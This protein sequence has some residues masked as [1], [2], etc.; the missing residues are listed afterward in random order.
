LLPLVFA[1]KVIKEFNLKTILIPKTGT[2]VPEY[3]RDFYLPDPSINSHVITITDFTRKYLIDNYNIPEDDI[4]LIYQGTDISSFKP[5]R[6][7]IRE[8]K[9]RYTLPDDSFPII[10]NIGSL[11]ERKGQSLL[12]ESFKD[13]LKTFP[14]SFLIFVGDGPDEKMLKEK[15]SELKIDKNV[16]FFPFT[17]EPNYVYGRIDILTL[18]SLYKEGL[19]NVLLESLAM[20]IPVIASNIAGVPEIVIDGETGFLS[21]PGNQEQL[22]TLIV[23]MASDREKMKLMGLTGRKYVTENFDKSR[24]FKIFL[25][26]FSKIIT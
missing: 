22:S 10:G 25:D 16:K 8:S 3:K 26:F 1:A 13:V 9:T 4:S 2:I 14:K 15:V 12:L 5:E 11:E 6:N 7:I 24:Q 23:K 20:E 18:P 21:E 19:P 17:R